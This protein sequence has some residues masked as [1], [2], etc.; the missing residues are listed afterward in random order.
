[1]S[2]TAEIT[3]HG[4][5]K[6]EL[7]RTFI[8]N[9]NMHEIRITTDAGSLEITAYGDTDVFNRLPKSDDFEAYTFRKPEAA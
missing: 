9:G 6:I 5:Q 8:E 7:C 1:V 4:V 3:L 2:K